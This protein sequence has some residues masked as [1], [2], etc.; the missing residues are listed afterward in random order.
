MEPRDMSKWAYRYTCSK[1]KAGDPCE[2]EECMNAK[3][4]GDHLSRA[5]WIDTI[6]RDGKA[7][8]GWFVPE[9]VSE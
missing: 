7:L 3:V 5:R 4:V 2:L 8:K 9:T 1:C 6:D